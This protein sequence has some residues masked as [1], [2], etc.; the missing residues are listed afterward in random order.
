[1]YPC[2]RQSTGTPWN[3]EGSSRNMKRHDRARKT[4]CTVLRIHVDGT[5]GS[6][7]TSVSPRRYL[8]VSIRLDA[9][10][11]DTAGPVFKK[12]PTASNTLAQ[13]IQHRNGLFPGD[14]GICE[15]LSAPSRRKTEKKTRTSNRLTVLQSGRSR[16]GDIL[17]TLDEVGFD[18]DTHDHGGRVSRL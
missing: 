13:P 12:G 8:C 4:R 18:H 17:T 7:Q 10:S 16:H 2:L 1:M 14:T 11:A 9:V 5:G 15:G 3:W 6:T